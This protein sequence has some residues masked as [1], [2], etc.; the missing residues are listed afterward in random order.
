MDTGTPAKTSKSADDQPQV[1]QA[2][3]GHGSAVDCETNIGK[4]VSLAA[5]DDV[6]PRDVTENKAQEALYHN[7]GK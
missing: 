1:D 2:G 5:Q 4:L 3:L 6:E 7:L